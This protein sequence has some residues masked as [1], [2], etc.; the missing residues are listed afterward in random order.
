M[1]KLIKL[2]PIVFALTACA[3]TFGSQVKDAISYEDAIQHKSS[4]MGK[5]ALIGGP[6][7]TYRYTDSS[8]QIEIANA[9]LN[10]QAVP[11]PRGDI[12]QRAIIVIHKI[13]PEEQ[14]QN[15][16]ISA[17]GPIREIAEN[18]RYGNSTVIMIS[19]DQYRIWRTAKPMFGPNSK[20][21]Y[22]Y[23]YKFE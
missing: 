13:I 16:R 11:S 19:A 5:T 18:T 8:T 20:E 9:P 4:A 21:R 17:I 22:G 23:T 14:I 3:S 15:V 10:E 2:L 12:K 7:I 6:I 1:L